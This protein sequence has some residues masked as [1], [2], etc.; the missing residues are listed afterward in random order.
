MKFLSLCSPRSL[1]LIGFAI[2]EVLTWWTGSPYDMELWIR[3]AYFVSCGTSPYNF[4]PSVLGLLVSINRSR[5]PTPWLLRPL[6]RKVPARD[7]PSES[8]SES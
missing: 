6:V 4:F 5:D 1:V 8:E 2:R 7:L 3:N